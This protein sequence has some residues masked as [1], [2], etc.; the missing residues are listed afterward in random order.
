MRTHDDYPIIIRPLTA[1][2]GGGYLAEVPDLPGCMRDGFKLFKEP[3][4]MLSLRFNPGFK[5]QRNLAIPYPS[6]ALR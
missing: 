2:D 5:P 6:P 3:Y 4:M 1:E